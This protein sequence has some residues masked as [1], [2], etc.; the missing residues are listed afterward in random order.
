MSTERK[1]AV[2]HFLES[3]EHLVFCAPWFRREGLCIFIYNDHDLAVAA[4]AEKAR[5]YAYD[6]DLGDTDDE[7]ESESSD[8]FLVDEDDEGGTGVEDLI[9]KKGGDEV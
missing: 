4:A 3:G 2:Y 5:L 7:D 1:S 6:I 9:P 8:Q